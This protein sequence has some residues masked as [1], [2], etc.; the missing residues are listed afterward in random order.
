MSL[1]VT[2]SKKKFQLF[3][4]MGGVCATACGPA[5]RAFGIT[6]DGVGLLAGACATVVNDESARTATESKAETRIIQSSLETI[7]VRILCPGNGFS[8]PAP[9]FARS[10]GARAA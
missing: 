10:G 7:S 8:N 6:F 2:L 1:S 3:H 5:N 4:P 9:R